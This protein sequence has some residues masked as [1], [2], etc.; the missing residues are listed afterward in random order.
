V[1]RSYYAGVFSPGNL[2]PAAV[3]DFARFIS[4]EFDVDFSMCDFE[5]DFKIFAT[6]EAVLT[7]QDQLTLLC[8]CGPQQAEEWILDRA[9]SSILDPE[10]VR[11]RGPKSI[12]LLHILSE[13]WSSEFV[14]GWDAVQ[15]LPRLITRVVEAGADLHAHDDDGLSPLMI[16]ITAIWNGYCLRPTREGCTGEM[17]R[18]VDLLQDANVNLRT[19]GHREGEY[20]RECSWQPQSFVIG[21]GL[22][23]SYYGF[24]YGAIPSEW[25]MWVGTPFDTY[26]GTFWALFESPPLHVPGAWPT[27]TADIKRFP[28][29]NG[30][31]PVGIKR[32]VFRR[33][34]R[35]VEAHQDPTV[36]SRLAEAVSAWAALSKQYARSN[37]QYYEDDHHT[38]GLLLELIAAARGLGIERAQWDQCIKIWQR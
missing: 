35:S 7:H 38:A 9:R 36:L 21:H 31:C 6:E 24:T 22:D 34:E 8:H 16:V 30:R 10:L 27:S 17:R 29:S 26:A 11:A 2:D 33:I 5:F 25:H 4:D 37:I 13:I 28:T 1:T 14:D 12:T 3:K 23:S 19:Y 15:A 20:Q 32:K 18:W